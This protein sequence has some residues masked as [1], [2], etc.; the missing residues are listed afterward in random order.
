MSLLSKKSSLL[1]K[2]L[3]LS[4]LVV[5][6]DDT[7]IGQS[8]S[9]D[10]IP[11]PTVVAAAED[12]KNLPSSP[13]FHELDFAEGVESRDPFRSFVSSFVQADRPGTR[14]QRSVLLA[15]YSVDEL[16][17]IGIIGR[18][19]PPMAMFEDPGGRGHLVKPGQYVGRSELVTGGTSGAE[20]EVNWR[21]ERIRDNDVVFERDDPSNP[22]IPSETKVIRLHLEGEE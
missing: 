12:G 16:H 21:V 8:T 17:L 14:S 22:D 20:Y 2:G 19:Q 6:C 5:A 1:A 7:P 11:T 18:I 13:K 3:L 4:T 9:P 15:E 10:V